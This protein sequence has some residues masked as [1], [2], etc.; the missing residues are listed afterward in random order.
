MSVCAVYSRLSSMPY[1]W[2]FYGSL[3]LCVCI[4]YW[5]ARTSVCMC[6]CVENLLWTNGWRRQVGKNRKLRPCAAVNRERV[7]TKVFRLLFVVSLVFRTIWTNSASKWRHTASRRKDFHWRL[8]GSIEKEK[9][10]SA[11]RNTKPTSPNDVT[12]CMCASAERIYMLYV[13]M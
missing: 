1:K 4:C 10:L 3:S 9:C 7:Q 12:N 2:L 8:F 5:K 11:V 6:V 13:V